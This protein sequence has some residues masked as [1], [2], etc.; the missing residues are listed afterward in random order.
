MALVQDDHVVQA[1]ATDTPD[2]AFHRGILPR[3]PRGDE[4]FF[5]PHV[6]YPLPKRGAVDTVPVVHEIAGRFVPWGTRPPPAGPSTLLW[7]A[8]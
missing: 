1:V 6:P 7:Y 3:T 8:Q 5:D 4:R 2:E